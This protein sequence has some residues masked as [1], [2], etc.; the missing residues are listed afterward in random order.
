MSD[1]GTF[2]SSEAAAQHSAGDISRAAAGGTNEVRTAIN[3]TTLSV[4]ENIKDLEQQLSSCN[5]EFKQLV[6]DDTKSIVKLSE[7]FADFDTEMSNDMN[8]GI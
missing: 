5:A 6:A 7:I 2:K 3:R 8:L 4:V 1:T